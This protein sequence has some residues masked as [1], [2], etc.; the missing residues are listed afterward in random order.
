MANSIIKATATILRDYV[1]NGGTPDERTVFVYGVKGSKEALEA[2]ADVQGGNLRED[3][4]GTPLYFTTKFAGET[5]SLLINTDK[6]TCYADM[7]AFRRQA[8]L[9]AQFGGSLGD[10]I[11]ANAFGKLFGGASTPAPAPK[12][13]SISSNP[14]GIGGL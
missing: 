7:S 9:A 2:Y 5:I 14:A 3:E 4:D 11:A 10:A 12:D 1:K 8:S 13:K 6:G